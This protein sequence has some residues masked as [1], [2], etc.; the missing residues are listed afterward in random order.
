MND[1]TV[2]FAAQ[3]RLRGGE[4][5]TFKSTGEIVD[6]VKG[7][8]VF[9]MKV[10]YDIAMLLQ[11]VMRGNATVY[12]MSEDGALIGRGLGD[13]VLFTGELPLTSAP[14]AIVL[15]LDRPI[16]DVISHAEAACFEYWF[17]RFHGSIGKMAKWA[18]KDRTSLYRFQKRAN[19]WKAKNE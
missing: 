3:V 5:R 19:D 1:I 17:G 10:P 15:K 16:D 12:Y 2:R 6:W 13:F 8:Q 11:P 4:F 9:G 18:G 7:R 14:N